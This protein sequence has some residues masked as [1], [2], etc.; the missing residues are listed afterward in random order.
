MIFTLSVYPRIMRGSERKTLCLLTS[1]MQGR[2]DVAGTVP[3]PT[4]EDA[5]TAV[6]QPPLL[7]SICG[8]TAER[9]F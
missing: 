4:I 1:F 9:A 7:P 3:F 2:V 6:E 8:W 5:I